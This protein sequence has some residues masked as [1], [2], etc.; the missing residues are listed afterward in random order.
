MVITR[1]SRNKIKN[2]IEEVLRIKTS[3]HEIAL[4]FSVGAFLAILPTFGLAF[5]IGIVLLL[6]FKKISKIG[7]LISFII[8]NPII[9]A[10]IYSLSFILGDLIFGDMPIVIVDLNLFQK[11]FFYSRRFL[12]GNLILAVSLSFISYLI[13][14]WIVKKYQNN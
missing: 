5:L 2:H 1:K 13:V 3:P 14:Y 12:V 7:M 6:I 11:I 4:G 10:G 9:L 8:F